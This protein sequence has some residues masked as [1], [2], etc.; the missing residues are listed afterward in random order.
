M[1]LDEAIYKLGTMAAIVRIVGGDDAIRPYASVKKRWHVAALAGPGHCYP[2]FHDDDNLLTAVLNVI[3]QIEGR[4]AQG[5]AFIEANPELKA[6]PV[7][8]TPTLF[9]GSDEN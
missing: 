5:S 4:R 2:P 6:L 7:T 8:V 1:T 3:S 9:P